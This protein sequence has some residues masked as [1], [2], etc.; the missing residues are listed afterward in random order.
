VDRRNPMDAHSMEQHE[1]NQNNGADN[2][3]REK[4]ELGGGFDAATRQGLTLD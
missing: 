3:G 2:D 1:G 4:R